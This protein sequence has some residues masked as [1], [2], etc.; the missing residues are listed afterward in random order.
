M[1]VRNR[2]IFINILLV[3]IYAHAKCWCIS[4]LLKKIIKEGEGEF[5]NAGDEVRAHYTGTLQDGSVFDS[6]RTRGKEFK[7]TL[8]QGNVIK[9]WDQGFASMRKDEQ[10][11]LRCRSD[12]AYGD[13]GAGDKI[14]AGAT[15]DF[16]VE[17]LGFGPK[18]KEKWQ[19][20]REEKVEE[21]SRLKEAGTVAFKDTRF[22]GAAELY[23]EAV[24]YLDNVEG[25]DAVALS[26]LCYLNAAQANLNLKNY[27]DA[28]ANASAALNKDP[29]NVKAL[30]RRGLA[31]NHMGSPE[32]ALEDLKKA[33]ELD[34]ANNPVKLE[35][36]KAKKAIQDAKAK[37]KAAYSNVFSKV[38]MYDDKPAPVVPGLSADNPK[39]FFDISIGGEHKGR[40][41]M[42]LYA[43]TTPKTA[44]N[45]RQ[46]CTGESERVASTGQKLHFKGSKFHRIIRDFMIQGGD[47]TM[48]N[49]MGGESIYGE[50][51][52]D[53]NF[54]VKHTEAGLL[55]MANAGPGTNGS[56]FFITARATPHLDGKHVVFGRVIEGMDIVRMLEN[57][58]TSSGDKP[59]ADCVIEDC[60]ELP[61][62]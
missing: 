50:K 14:P 54:K 3:L 12:Y 1:E 48:G 45:F 56:Q 6:S 51:F 15:L 29:S 28:S 13:A 37:T 55:S 23:L 43:D 53:E 47:F 44:E 11:I 26:V 35:I 4:G 38:S 20:S 62:H 21:A 19:M 32:E 31:K 58:P 57:T 10:A 18:K 30:Y 60:G 33:L 52:A 46:L 41:V 40:I 59:V 9:G 2:I 24:E 49:G 7:F 27:A 22:T 5:P 34:P 61:K 36:Q 17:L 42:L 8:G 16:D 39:V 25:D